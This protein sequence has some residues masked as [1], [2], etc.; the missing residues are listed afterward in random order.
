MSDFLSLIVLVIVSVAL[1][2]VFFSHFFITNSK[3]S[4]LSSKEQW[5]NMY[6]C[7]YVYIYCIQFY[8]VL[9]RFAPC[10]AQFHLPSLCVCVRICAHGVMRCVLFLSVHIYE[11]YFFCCLFILLL[12]L[13]SQ[14]NF[15]V[16]SDFEM[17]N[18]RCEQTT[19]KMTNMIITDIIWFCPCQ[20]VIV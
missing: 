1:F 8:G 19:I 16:K 3:V 13:Y 12:F 17:R 18:K 2:L 6:V 14:T 20:C 15:V 5:S 7:M 4:P 10:K 11:C 9:S